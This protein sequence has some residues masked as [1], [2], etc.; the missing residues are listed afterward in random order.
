MACQETKKDGANVTIFI[1]H[2]GS[3]YFCFRENSKF[4]DEG[5]EEQRLPKRKELRAERKC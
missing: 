3:I 1:T 2:L 5:K 4:L